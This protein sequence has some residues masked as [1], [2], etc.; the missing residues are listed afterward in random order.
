MAK[1]VGTYRLFVYPPAYTTTPD[2][3]AHSGQI[4]CV[5]RKLTA[6]EY[7]YQGECM[8]RCR[9]AD[10]WVGDIWRSELCAATYT[11][12]DSTVKDGDAATKGWR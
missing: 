1:I 4:V 6:D 3:T 11:G 9:T 5:E 10:G 7:D 8:Y 2:Y 12:F